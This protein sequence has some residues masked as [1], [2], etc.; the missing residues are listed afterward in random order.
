MQIHI[1]RNQKTFGPYSVSLIKDFLNEEKIFLTDRAWAP[2]CDEWMTIKDLLEITKRDPLDKAPEK[3]DDTSDASSSDEETESNDEL[4]GELLCNCREFRKLH[5]KLREF[6][7]LEILNMERSELVNSSILSWLLD[8]RS[9]HNLGNLFLRRWMIKILS[10]HAEKKEDL[11]EGQVYEPKNLPEPLDLELA[12]L[13]SVEVMKEHQLIRSDRRRIDLFL[14][15]RTEKRGT[16]QVLIENKVKT[17]QRENQLDDYA[18]LAERNA[19]SLKEQGHPKVKTILLFLRD[20]E[21]Q[22]MGNS[23]KD[24]ICC[25]YNQIF[26]VL[27]EILEDED[28]RIP[29]E[30]KNF[31]EYYKDALSKFKSV[32][33]NEL[34]ELAFEILGAHWDAVEKI[35]HLKKD[36][37]IRKIYEVVWNFL[38]TK[39][40]SKEAFVASLLKRKFEEEVKN[41][42][43]EKQSIERKN[44]TVYFKPQKLRG[45]PLIFELRFKQTDLGMVLWIRIRVKE[46]ASGDV[47]NI[48]GE[49]KTGG[50]D[51]GDSLKNIKKSGS[52]LFNKCVSLEINEKTNLLDVVKNRQKEVFAELIN[53]DCDFQKALNIIKNFFEGR[54][55]T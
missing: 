8:E 46:G 7:P 52:L 36:D 10:D 26:E 32:G 9:T 20:G 30:E 35:K 23:K 6:N 47:E 53:T 24:W 33:Q 1:S 41:L 4:I 43:I 19:S 45:L 31:I 39:K 55:S 16:W 25:D 12:N 27:V 54:K 22:P 28:T 38:T 3:T 18:N 42:D 37:E 21:E 44:N 34:Q 11:N 51:Q 15:V 50:L 29:N 5:N 49:L 40:K 48:L 14:E 13:I 17:H 2:V